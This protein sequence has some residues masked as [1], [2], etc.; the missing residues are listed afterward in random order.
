MVCNNSSYM[1]KSDS[2][3]VSRNGRLLIWH[4]KLQLTGFLACLL[5][6]SGLSLLFDILRKLIKFIELFMRYVIGIMSIEHIHFRL[7][8]IKIIQLAHFS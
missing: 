6:K 7:L 8:V 3:S 1:V 5:V 2:F 4:N